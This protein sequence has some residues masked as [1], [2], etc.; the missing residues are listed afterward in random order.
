MTRPPVPHFPVPRDLRLMTA[1]ATRAYFHDRTPSVCT[2]LGLAAILAPL[3]VLFGLKYGVVS[4]L[5]ERLESDPRI[6]IIQPIGQGSFDHA[7]FDQLANRPETGFV[8]PTT[9]FLAATVN[10]RNAARPD[11]STVSAEL[12]PTA[13][14]DPLLDPAMAQRLAIQP[15]G[16][17][18]QIALSQAA[19]ERLG[20]AAGAPIEGRIG[21]TYRN[22]PEIVTLNLTAAAILSGSPSDRD[23]VLVP[24]ALL[25]AAEDY[26]EGDAVTD[27][28]SQGQPR[29][30]GPRL[31]ASF[32]LYARTIDGVA[33]L[34][35]WLADHGVQ[36]ITRLAEI[37][38]VQALD[39]DLGRLFLL[40]SSLGAGGYLVSM[41][42]GLWASVARQRR[43]LS[44]LR[45]VGFPALAISLFPVVQGL[46]AALLSLLV[47]GLATW[48]SVPVVDHLMASQLPPGATIFRLLPEHVAVAVAVTLLFTIAAASYGGLRAAAIPPAE[49]MRDE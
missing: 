6:R 47:A 7:W 18:Y 35:T 12:L 33:G 1:I 36:S 40:I 21:R 9:R 25:E 19:A 28:D 34:R 26:R 3:F 43:S 17:D 48:L 44:L 41:A 13:P 11:A 15:A 8:V 23:V 30:D 27:F 49:G 31:Y 29:P 24:L 22:E 38:T 32:R 5:R 37:E 2:L 45:L 14:G 16:R 46:W 10:L 20:I 4:A 39:R 42:L